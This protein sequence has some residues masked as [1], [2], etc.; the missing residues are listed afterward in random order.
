MATTETVTIL[1]V[2]TDEAVK[3][4]GELR[5]NIKD[6]KLALENTQTDSAEG[7]AEYQKTLKEL[8]VNQNALKDVMYAT[9]ASFGDVVS[10]ARGAGDSYNALVHRMAELK[11]ELRSTD[12]STAEGMESFKQLASQI[13][14]VNDRLKEMDALQGNFQRNVGNYKSHWEGLAKQTD[15]LDKGLKTLEGGVGGLK[16]GFEALSASP[17][18]ATFSIFVSIA[19]KLAQAMKEDENAM[20]GVRKVLASLKPVMDFFKGVLSTIGTYLGDIFVKISDYIGSSGILSKVI[21]SVMGVGNAILK[22]VVAPF[23]AVAAAI[24]VFKEQ[25]IKGLKDATKAFADEMKSGISFKRNFEAGQSAA[26]AMASGLKSGKAEVV[27]AAQE[28]A[29]ETTQK[30]AKVTE[31]MLNQTDA[32]TQAKIE[33]ARQAAEEQKQWNEIAK[34]DA[35]D[36]QAFV[37]EVLDDIAR[38]EDENRARTEENIKAREQML[39]ALASTTSSILSSIADMYESDAEDSKQA[40]EKVKAMRIAAATIDT[41]SGAVGA[42]TQAAATIP[43]PYGIIVGA[44]QAATVTATGMVNIA[45]MRSTNVGGSAASAPVSVAAPSVN[46]T[47]V[48]SVRNVTSATE[49]ERLNKMAQDQRVYILSSDIEASQNAIKTQVAET[50]F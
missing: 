28:I 41:I 3:S 18:I 21:D 1:R 22:F 31:A 8:K 50:S 9:S 14:N 26:A 12:V 33:A 30:L 23:K 20:E 43:P 37:Q 32:V 40:E 27:Q 15:A 29:E 11:R 13:N 49:E 16:N 44:A 10:G 47:N 34:A 45:K 19:I 46:T 17:A 6:L 2:G 24:G 35:E 48:S 36:A 4:V 7:W 39:Y 25:G 38:Q 42:Y 5:D